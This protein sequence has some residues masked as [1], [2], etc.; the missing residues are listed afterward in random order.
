LEV[1]GNIIVPDNGSLNFGDSTSK[2]KGESFANDTIDVIV[3]GKKVQRFFGG[4]QDIGF[5]EDTGTTTKFYWD[6]SAERLG[7]GT[8]SPS[9][10]LEISGT[11][12]VKVPVGTDGE[13]PTGENG[14]LRYNTT[15][16][17]FEGY[18][19]GAWGP[20]GGAVEVETFSITV[21]GANATS[22]WSGS[23]PS[24]ATLTVPGIL[25]TDAPVVSLDISGETFDDGLFLQR[26]WNLVYRVEASADDEIKLYAI[27]EPFSDLTVNIKVTR[28]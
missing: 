4:T 3:N 22:D 28:G 6:A 25:S 26:V 2:I 16:S 7:I 13:R 15:S 24:V 20:I 12:A 8:S 27:E 5:Y 14:Q 19:Q 21:T 17:T 9:T 1:N 11:D 23:E 18:A 10:S